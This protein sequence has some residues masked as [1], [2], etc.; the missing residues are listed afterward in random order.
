MQEWVL[1]YLIRNSE[2][3]P[4]KQMLVM[5]KFILVGV[6]QLIIPSNVSYHNYSFL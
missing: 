6:N 1:K 2:Y 4:A 5:A 3:G